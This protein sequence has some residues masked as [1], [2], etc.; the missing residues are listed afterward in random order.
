MSEPVN[1]GFPTRY[2]PSTTWILW[3]NLLHPHDHPLFRRTLRLSLETESLPQTYIFWIVPLLSLFACCGLIQLK[4]AFTI[5][6]PVALAA[7]G[8]SYSIIWVIRITDTIYKEHERGTYDQLSLI[9]SGALGTT[10]ALATAALHRSDALGWID[11]VR[12]LLT[13]LLMIAL[14]AILIT[15]TLRQDTA[16]LSQFWLLLIEMTALAAVS[17]AD[18]V[19]T[20]VLG[21]LVGMLAAAHASDALDARLSGVLLFLS[22][23]AIT[24]LATL[25]TPILFLP[26]LSSLETAV[27]WNF[28]MSPLIS[29]LLVFYGSREALITVCWQMLARQLNA[30][31]AEFRFWD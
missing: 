1:T 21:S 11:S 6:L 8:S 14:L 18:H 4:S 23:Q 17:Y 16:T 30:N 29:G 9:P 20:M 12:K 25:L 19:Q 28:A 2:S 13:I 10:W 7:F 22:L 15:T 5:I 27:H 26:A 24:C 3:R 31:P